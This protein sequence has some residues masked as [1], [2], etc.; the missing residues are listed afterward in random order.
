MRD[1]KIWG[2]KERKETNISRYIAAAQR[3][4]GNLW[5][6]FSVCCAR[7]LTNRLHSDRYRLWT[8]AT[9][10]FACSLHSNTQR[11]SHL[12]T[13]MYILYN[14]HSH[15]RTDPRQ[16]LSSGTD[17]KGQSPGNKQEAVTSWWVSN[18]EPWRQLGNF[19]IL[20]FL[21]FSMSFFIILSCFLS[22][23]SSVSYLFLFLLHLSLPHWLFTCTWC[24]W[25]ITELAGNHN[26]FS[27]SV[28]T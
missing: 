24:Y 21:P 12:R 10:Q 23:V 17:I 11:H 2:K 28:I 16:T 20:S 27:C 5:F 14:T 15:T 13:H 19:Y 8:W 7:L 26:M 1:W 18:F 6:I 4:N 9:S 3:A 22:L 25:R